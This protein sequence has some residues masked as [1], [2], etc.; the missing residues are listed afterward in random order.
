[1][2]GARPHATACLPNGWEPPVVFAG[3]RQLRGSAPQTVE[4]R[5]SAP[6]TVDALVGVVSCRADARRVRVR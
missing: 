2:R 6:Q 1:M 5:G 4:F 3:V